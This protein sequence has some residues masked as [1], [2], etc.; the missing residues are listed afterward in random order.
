VRSYNDSNKSYIL[1]QTD[2]RFGVGIFIRGR[3]T[4]D[5]DVNVNQDVLVHAFQPSVATGGQLAKPTKTGYMLYTS[6]GVFQLFE[7]HRANTFIFLN[8]ATE[9]SGKDI[10][11]SIALAKISDN[12][13]VCFKY[14]STISKPLLMPSYQRQIGRIQ[15][16]QVERIEI[17]VVSNRDRVAQEAFDLR[18]SQLV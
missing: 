9:F 4:W 17:H 14:Y 15:K 12:V 6:D 5:E 8:F 16:S 3:H 1:S 10:N 2:A 7:R 11:V 18:F 13:R